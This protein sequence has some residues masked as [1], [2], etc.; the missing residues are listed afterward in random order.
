MDGKT[1]INYIRMYSLEDWLFFVLFMFSIGSC[2]SGHLGTN[3]IRIAVVL[4]FILYFRRSFPITRFIVVR[5]MFYTYVVFYGTM[6]FS[7]WWSRLIHE[8]VEFYPPLD[9][10]YESLLIFCIILSKVKEKQIQVLY[11]GIFLSLFLLGGYLILAFFKGVVRPSGFYGSILTNST[12]YTVLIPPLTVFFFNS[13]NN[14]LIRILCGII[15]TVSM[16]AVIAIGTRGIWIALLFTLPMVAYFSI[17]WKRSMY[18]GIVCLIITAMFAVI[19]PVAIQ[20]RFNAYGWA[21]DASVTA[22]LAMYNGAI[23]MFF[24]HPVLGVGMGNFE[25]FWKN[26]YYPQEKPQWKKFTHP[27]SSHLQFLACGGLLG[28]TGY[29]IFWGYLLMWSWRR[30]YTNHGLLLLG[31]TFSL[32]LYGI[33]DNPLG[34]HEGM[35]VYWF[36]VGL[37]FASEAAELEKLKL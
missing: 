34:T 9:W 17:G 2:V 15:L 28:I 11:G 25:E 21:K 35:R 10:A 33:T 27:H 29:C 4:C 5:Q 37:A 14:K 19:S 24:D 20:N 31:S 22:R 1:I 23:Q 13:R 12:F 7:T 16:V 18:F 36:I 32:L 3:S 6:L 30:R 8:T 26:Q